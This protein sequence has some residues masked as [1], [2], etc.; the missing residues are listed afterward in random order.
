[1]NRKTLADLMALQGM[2]KADI[3]RV[4]LVTPPTAAAW[5]ERTNPPDAKKR[6]AIAQHFGV[7]VLDIQWE[8]TT[9]DML[10]QAARFR[11]E[12]E[13]IAARNALEAVKNG[14]VYTFGDGTMTGPD[15]KQ[16]IDKRGNSNA[17]RPKKFL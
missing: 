14:A 11:A 15:A 8:D 10:A 17:R 1:M 7:S 12:A 3:A 5:A 4:F 6:L 13:L 9:D 16:Y 2:S